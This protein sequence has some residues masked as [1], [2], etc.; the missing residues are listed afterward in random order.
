MDK[1]KVLRRNKLIKKLF[2]KTMSLNND[3]IKTPCKLR[4]QAKGR[5]SGQAKYT[6]SKNTL[7]IRK[8]SVVINPT[9]I[10]IWDIKKGYD[11]FYYTGRAEKINRYI[12]GNYK[13]ALRFVLLHEVGHIIFYNKYGISRIHN[14]SLKR[15]EKYADNFAIRYIN[16]I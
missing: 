16:A 4:I 9:M 11:N 2:E 7:L 12:V 5:I 15:K 1:I 8:M 14:T 10:K 3:V 6:Y 13:K